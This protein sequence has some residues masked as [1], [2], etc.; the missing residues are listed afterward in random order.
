MSADPYRTDKTEIRRNFNRAAGSYD[1]VAA[2]Q[3][4]P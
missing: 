1:R 2:L 3:Q 4:N